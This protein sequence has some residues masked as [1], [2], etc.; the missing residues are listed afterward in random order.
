MSLAAPSALL[1]LT[2]QLTSTAVESMTK[3]AGHVVEAHG[4]MSIWAWLRR[5]HRR[6]PR[7]DRV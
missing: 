4:L 5:V 6:A 2:G 1:V 7:S 3:T